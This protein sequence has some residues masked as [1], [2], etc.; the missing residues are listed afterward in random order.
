VDEKMPDFVVESY[1]TVDKAWH[2]ELT[3]DDPCTVRILIENLG[4][5]PI[6]GFYVNEVDFDLVQEG[7]VNDEIL[8][9][10]SSQELSEKEL[11]RADTEV[12]FPRGTVYICIELDCQ[13]SPLAER[14][15]FS[16][17]LSW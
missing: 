4:S 11:G 7:I 6:Y 12:T 15:D 14:A 8:D 9:R 17:S 16:V 10:I 3:F 1:V 2:Q 13:A 5:D